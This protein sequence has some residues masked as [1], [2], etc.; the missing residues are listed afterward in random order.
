MASAGAVLLEARPFRPFKSSEEYLYAM[1]EDLAEWLTVLYPELRINADNFLDRLDTGVAL[2]RHANAVRESARLILDGPA[3]ESD[4][5]MILAKALRTRPAVNMLPAA[6]A[7]TFFARD[8]LS[9]FI[10][11]CRRA[12]GILECLLF[13]TDDLCLRKNEKHV[14]LC[15]LEV[16][17]KGAVLGMPAPLL[18]QMEKQIERELAGEELRPDDSALGLVP[19]GPQPQLVTNDLRSLDERVRDL[20]ERCSCP[21]QFPMVRVSEGKYRIGDTRMLIFVRILRSHVMVRVGGGWDTLAHY[22]D[23]HDPCR[24]RAQHRTSL[25]ARLARPK[26]DLAGATVTY[27]RPDPGPTS[28][29]YKDHGTSLQYKEP[30]TY[31]PMSLPYTKVYNDDPRSNHYLSNN[32]LDAPSSLPYM[33]DIDRAA[34]PSRKHL[35]PR[36]SS[37]IRNNRHSSSPDRRTKIVTSNHLVP[38]PHAIRNKSPRPVSPAPAAESAS[39]NGSEVSDEGYRSLG[40]VAGSTQG[41]PSTKTTNR[42]SL[43]S[44]N[45]MDDADFSERLDHDDGCHIDKSDRVDD[46]VSLNTGLRKTDFSDTFY[47]SRK[48]SADDKS[49]RA[50]P[51]CIVSHESNDSPSKSL[52]PAREATQSPVKTVRSRQVSRIP[53]SPV[54]NRTP[55]RANTPS[56]KHTPNQSSPKLAPKLPPTSR[57]TWGG[58]TAPNQAKTK[59][60]P[61]IGAD[62]FE[63]PNK[64]PKTKT[65]APQNEAFKRNSP[66]RASS[67]TLRS[68][69]H[70]K[71]LSPLLEQILRSAESAK[72][73]ASVLEKMKEIIRSYSKGEDSVSRASSKDSDYADFTSAWVM[74]DG[75]LERS[76]ST[77]QLAA[78]RKDPRNGASRIPAPVALG[79]RRSTSTS[80]F[81]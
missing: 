71:Q 57:N 18:V 38:S 59:A 22:L 23:K 64:S 80:Q 63:N 19:C 3:P 40:V 56:P 76:T 25:S 17:R 69:T 12:L 54:R 29:Q 15:L 27:E 21:T 81:Q 75:K 5:A 1:K 31:E 16:A 45:S 73:D 2:C 79:C 10:D 67:A 13:E 7:G 6:K 14:V 44:Q 78:P 42:Y 47:G 72:D 9:N 26:H 28:L 53:H 61:A 49:N 32:K 70:Q 35:T 46:Y 55:S 65:K 41:S 51:E 11:W 30:K 48:N 37:P 8:N 62:T 43:H 77:R 68:P 36:N 4:D 74:S 60:R 66:L 24:C 50:S 34:S 58:R 33:G 20:V 39:D 52:R